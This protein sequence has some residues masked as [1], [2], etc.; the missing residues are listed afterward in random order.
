LENQYYRSNPDILREAKKLDEMA[1]E[2]F[3]RHRQQLA[4]GTTHVIE[5]AK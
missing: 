5:V 3:E 4:S 2:I 1:N